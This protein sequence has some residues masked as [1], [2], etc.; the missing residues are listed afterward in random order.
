MHISSEFIEKLR[1]NISISEIVARKTKLIR[2]GREYLGLCPFHNEKTPSFTVND[3]KQFY[4]CFGCNAHGDIVKFLTDTKGLSFIEAVKSLA[5]EAGIELPK[6][7]NINQ[8]QRKEIK[9][10]EHLLEIATKWYIEQLSSS[11]GYAAKDYLKKRNISDEAIKKFSI[12]YAPAGNGLKNHLLKNGVSERQMIECG[13][14]ILPENKNSYDRFRSRI[15]F[16]IFNKYNKVLG[17]GGRSLGDEQPK[18]LNSPETILFKKGEILYGENFAKETAFKNKRIIIVEGYMDVIA[19][20]MAGFTE[21]VASLGTAITEFHIKN[22]WKMAPEPIICLDGDRAGQNA[23]KRVSDI[24]LPV[25]KAGCSLRFVTLPDNQDPDEIIKHHGKNFMEKLLNEAEPLS[26]VLWKQE[27]SQL[28]L[29]PTPE[30]KALCENNLLAI[31]EK[32]NDSKVK[33]NYRSYFLEKIWENL[34][35]KNNFK[36]TNSLKT[37]KNELLKSIN[38][39]MD[40]I[41]RCELNLFTLILNY[42]TLLDDHYIEE[43]FTLLELEN[44]SLDKLRIAILQTKNFIN[45]EETN[46]EEFRKNLEI[47]L[48]KMEFTY[49]L[50]Y[51]YNVSSNLFTIKGDYK[52]IKSLWICSI[53]KYHIALL[54]KERQKALNLLTYESLE[55]ALAL[56]VQ[57]MDLEQYII[58]T[59]EEFI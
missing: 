48:E 15:I 40:N 5:E 46:K 19:M 50:N 12:G 10:L 13:L 4:H 11:N 36:K 3:E 47:S 52:E 32:I 30:Q 21:T 31:T 14:T 35:R 56:E 55:K 1:N 9:N 34:K 42:P 38:I 28:K 58:K 23:M 26:E 27:Y 29:P 43:E 59:T 8:D 6:E 45:I 2:K 16:P 49:D 7:N 17:F 41:E 25:L 18:Y 57:I 53:S 20:H 39:Q 24:V 44:S 22:L 33:S 37:S 51:L 54:H